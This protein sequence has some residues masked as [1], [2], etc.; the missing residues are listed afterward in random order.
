MNLE[1]QI[2]RHIV[3]PR[4]MFFATVLPGFESVCRQE[5]LALSDSVE[6]ISQVT[7]GV[8]F[9]ARLVDLYRANLCLHTPGRILMRISEFKA[10][11][12]R[13]LAKR[14]GAIY[15]NIG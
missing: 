15:F 5:V 11:N 3:G 6:I 12:F 13:Q 2:K 7:G 10:T 9:S 8:T 4:Q 14:L 1:K